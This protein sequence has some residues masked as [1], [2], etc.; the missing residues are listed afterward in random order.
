SFARLTAAL[1]PAVVIGAALYLPAGSFTD[2]LGR[3]R[4]FFAGQLLLIS[5]LLTVAQTTNLAVAGAAAVVVFAG[6]VLC[7]PAWNAAV[8]DLA[9][10]THR[11]T[12]IGLSVALSG[13]GLA[14]GP[15]LGGA[16]TDLASPQAVFRVAAGISAVT[17]VGV[18]LYGRAYGRPAW[19]GQPPLLDSPGE[20]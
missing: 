8:M 4:P 12:L 15:A 9:P 20:G 16:I 18:L 17:G 1:I 14:I 11:G 7:V 5:G 19:A 3:T 10:A 2:R 6:N 13:L